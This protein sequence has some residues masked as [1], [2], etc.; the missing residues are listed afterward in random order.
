MSKLSVMLISLLVVAAFFAGVNIK[1][2]S[3][4]PTETFAIPALNSQIHFSTEVNYTQ[5]TLKTIHG[6]SLDYKLSGR[7]DTPYLGT[8]IFQPKTV[9]YSYLTFKPGL[10][11]KGE[12]DYNG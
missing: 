8:C 7:Q 12:W 11:P 10:C 1:T 2:S 4:L 6:S 3:S 5:Q 9:Q